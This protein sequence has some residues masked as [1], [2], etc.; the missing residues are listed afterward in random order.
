[1]SSLLLKGESTGLE[2][3]Y[4]LTLN[5]HLALLPCSLE[6]CNS[7]MLHLY[8]EE[9]QWSK[10]STLKLNRGV[11]SLR[12][13]AATQ[14][15]I[16]TNNRKLQKDTKDKS[17]IPVSIE[18]T[19][20]KHKKITP[21]LFCSFNCSATKFEFVKNQS[22]FLHHS[23]FLISLIESVYFTTWFPNAKSSSHTYFCEHV[24][25]AKF[26]PER[27]TLIQ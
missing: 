14:H 1:M 27:S 26:I 19:Y 11:C 15:L 13:Q 7:V 20:T 17:R 22:Y 25:E 5:R 21:Y 8:C 2:M 12:N 6:K 10:P 4:L 24:Q 9:K 3:R 16:P 23:I 18:S